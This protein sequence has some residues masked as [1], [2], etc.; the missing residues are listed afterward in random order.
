MRH[1]SWRCHRYNTRI[2]IVPPALGI[3]H[4][5]HNGYIYITPLPV[6]NPEDIPKRAELFMKRAGYYYQNWDR[7]HDQWEVKLRGII[8]KLADLEIP[9]PP[10]MED[11]SVVTEGLGVSTGYKLLKAYDELIDL[12]IL[13][14]Q[15]HFEFLNLG[16]AAVRDLRRFLH[17]GVS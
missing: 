6:A 4:R 2:F 12:G 8:K 10:E 7:L 15:Y 3:D 9:V 17:Q 11:E 1:G 16:Y 13:A 14:W 5:I